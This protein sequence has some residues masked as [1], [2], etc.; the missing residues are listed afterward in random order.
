[1]MYIFCLLDMVEEI[2][3]CGEI[4]VQCFN[5]EYLFFIWCG[6]WDYDELIVEVDKKMEVVEVVWVKSF[7]LEM[8]DEGK[9][10]Q[11]LVELWCVFYDKGIGILG[12]QQVY[13]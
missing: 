11:L 4:I 5:C 3:E 2:L 13:V 8:V 9:I 7:L 6:E 10:E 12:G 1:M